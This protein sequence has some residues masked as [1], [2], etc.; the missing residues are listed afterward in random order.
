MAFMVVTT[1][2]A[3]LLLIKSNLA[4]K[5]YLLVGV[6]IVLLALAIMLLKEAY[7]ALRKPGPPA[8]QEAS[9]GTEVEG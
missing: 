2:A 7:A 6:A 1:F 9:P 4:S 3:L 5:N 8:P